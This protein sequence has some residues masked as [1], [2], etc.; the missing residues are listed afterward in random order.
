MAKHGIFDSDTKSLK[1]RMEVNVKGALYNLEDWIIEQIQP[2]RGMHILD[3]GCGTGKQIFALS[4]IVTPDG[5]LVG[6]DISQDAISE[7]NKRKRE[8]ALSHIRAI[9]G[10]LDECVTLLCDETFDCILSTYAIYYA[11][12]M[13]R[14]LAD[15]KTLLKPGGQLFVCGPGRGTNQEMTNIINTLLDSS[16]SRVNLIEDFISESD[17][18]VIAKHYLKYNVVRLSNQIRFDSVEDVLCWWKNHNSFI[19]R[20]EGAVKS[21]VESTI[22]EKKTFVLTKNVLG[23]HFFV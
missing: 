21:A 19:H 8:E 3:L 5:S 16:S 9:V 11:Q 4:E 6:L 18:E 20:I 14:V 12:D 17:I 7:V 22:D 10:S 1:Q 23:V 13:K 15:L 2:R